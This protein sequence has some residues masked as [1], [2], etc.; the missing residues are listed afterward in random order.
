[1][2]KYILIIV[3]ILIVGTIWWLDRNSG[4]A[5]VETVTTTPVS[6]DAAQKAGQY[7]RVPELVDPS[8]FIN[9]EPFKISD[10][11]GK[12]VILVDFWTYSCIN[13]QRTLPYLTA[14]YAKYRD[15]GLEIVGIHSPEFDFEK[16]RANVEAAVKQFGIEYPVVMDNNHTTWSNFRNRYWPHEYLVD[17]D[18]YIVHDHIGEGGYAET[19]QEIQKLLNERKQALGEGGSVATGIVNPAGAETVNA[20]SPETYFGSDRNELFGNGQA[21]KA[22]MQTLT[23]PEKID[24]NTLYLDGSWNFTGEY[25]QNT[26][27]A[28]IIYRYQ[29]G[30]VF[31]VASSDSGVDLTILR[32]G[33]PV[34]SASGSDVK[35]GQVTVKA[36]RLY[37]LI[38]D[39][40]GYGEH[41]LE[42]D[43]PE[44]GLDAYTFTFG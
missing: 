14:W 27:P 20:S 11:V 16:E 8:G 32:D 9:T 29:A 22:G 19:E 4:L 37:R 39:P 13:C 24:T 26:T 44:P 3:L 1:M 10:L 31:L 40:A 2:R 34:G 15:Q 5:P 38:E 35:D 6:M 7:E 25:A 23:V 30:K 33:Q 36:N 12:K 41:T 28:R 21:G 42:I 17:I 43:I 18:G